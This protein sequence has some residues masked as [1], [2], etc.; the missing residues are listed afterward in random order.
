MIF[1]LGLNLREERSKQYFSS[2]LEQEFEQWEVDNDV[3]NIDRVFSM[4]PSVSMTQQQL[5][6]FEEDNTK[7]AED[8]EQE[9][10]SIVKSIVDLNEIFKD[11]AHLVSNQVSLS[12]KKIFVDV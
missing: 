3:E 2:A 4:G 12:K 11:L 6:L 7:I 1:C 8:R 10:K 5:M 9:V